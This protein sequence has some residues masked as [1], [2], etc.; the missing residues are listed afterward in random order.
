[1]GHP[2]L[3]LERAAWAF[4][5]AKQASPGGP[6]FDLSETIQIEPKK[7][8]NLY[9]FLGAC[10][11]FPGCKWGQPKGSADDNSTWQNPPALKRV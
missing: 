2:G 7:V 1:M 3:L 11:K 8:N 6:I 5:A 4:S 10:G 9:Q